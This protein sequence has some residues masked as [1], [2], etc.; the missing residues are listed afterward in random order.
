VSDMPSEKSMECAR[1]WIWHAP[2]C[3]AHKHPLVACT[4]AWSV[5]VVEAARAIDERIRVGIETELGLRSYRQER[6]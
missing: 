2:D 4:C 3:E 5:R 1:A 6:P